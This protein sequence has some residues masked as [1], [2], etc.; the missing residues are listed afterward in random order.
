LTDTRLELHWAAQLIAAVPMAFLE[1]TPD[2]S[3]ANLGWLS[4]AATFVTR[5]VGSASPVQ[6]GLQL[7][8]FSLVILDIGGRVI[9]ALVLVGRTLDEGY[10]WIAELMAHHGVGTRSAGELHRPG[11]DFPNHAV[12]SGAAFSGGAAAA[13]AELARWYDNSLFTLLEVV[14]DME[15]ASSVRTWPHHFDMAALITLKAAEDAEQMRSVGV[16]MTPGDSSYAEPYFY[17][18]PWP[19]PQHPTLPSLD[20]HGSWHT[21]G[22]IGAVLTGSRLIEGTADG[23]AQAERARDLLE[24][25]I[26]AVRALAGG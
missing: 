6:V 2:F 18:V 7:D 5:P 23:T 14:H 11:D 26:P 22:W 3:H 15:S 20:G 17:V 25:A 16:G 13:R 1:Q 8:D 9:D 24:S 4:R 21:E 19:Y 12:G 10:A